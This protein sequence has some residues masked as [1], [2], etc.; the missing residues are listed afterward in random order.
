MLL[1]RKFPAGEGWIGVTSRLPDGR[2]SGG[3]LRYLESTDQV[4]PLLTADLMAWG[5]RG[6]GLAGV[7][8]SPGNA[9]RRLQ[10]LYAGLVAPRGTEVRVD[11][12]LCADVVTVGR[13]D[14]RTYLTLRRGDRTKIVFAGLDRFHPVLNGYALA[15]VSVT[16]D[17]VVV[18]A[19]D[20]APIDGGPT[21]PHGG[22]GET[23]G[24]AM[25]FRG[26]SGGRPIPYVQPPDGLVLTSVLGW[27]SDASTTW[28]TGRVA[29]REG[30]YEVDAGP[31]AGDRAPRLLGS[32]HGSLFATNADD[33]T[34]IFADGGA[35]SALRD[36]RLAPLRLPA[37]AP[38]PTGPIVWIR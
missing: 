31:S 33:G 29:G 7:R 34:A 26:L 12:P 30:I 35:L 20:R 5:A 2:F 16:A 25:F 38:A 37:G 21:G 13:D 14:L 4:T 27:S 8:R 23:G 1:A 15:S 24:A 28:V 36:G 22:L 11:R 6:E 18:P 19:S 3:V 17:L 32:V 9:C 10:V